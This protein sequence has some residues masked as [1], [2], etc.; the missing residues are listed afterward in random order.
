MN[1]EHGRTLQGLGLSDVRTVY[2]PVVDLRDGHVV[3]YEALVRGGPD[4][5]LRSPAELFEHA[6]AQDMRR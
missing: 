6:R 2:Q 5:A 4:N 1:P 3:G